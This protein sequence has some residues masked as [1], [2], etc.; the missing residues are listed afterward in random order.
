GQFY[1][2]IAVAGNPFNPELRT[3][4]DAPAYRM[5]RILLPE[6]AHLAGL[7]RPATTL[8]AYALSNVVCWVILAW[9][10][11]R[12]WFRPTSFENLVRWV[13]TMFGAGVLVSATRSLTDG[14]SLL[15]LALGMRCLEL[16]R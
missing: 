6:L 9:I 3:A 12:W 7:G 10:T 2:Q 11:A 14:P 16:N 8:A 1:A 5:R 15:V 13:G 4:L